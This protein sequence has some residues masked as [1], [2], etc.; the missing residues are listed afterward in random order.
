MFSQADLQELLSFDAGDHRVLSL[1]LNAD[2]G[3]ESRET[4]KLR[5]RNLLKEAGPQHSADAEAIERYL[6]HSHDWSKP[7]LAIFSCAA[8]D[9]FRVYETA[10]AFRNRIR[11]NKTPYVKPIA[12]LLDYYAHY[13]VVLVD[14]VGARFFEYHLGEL[15]ET[16]GTIGE[17]VRKLKDG[18]G[19]SAVG[20]RG[21]GEGARQENEAIQR[22]L[23]E[24]A[25]EAMNFFANRDIRRLFIGGTAETVAQ[26]REYLPKQLQTRIANTFSIDMDAPE[27]EVREQTIELLKEANAIREQKLVEAMIT[28]AAKNG[29]A[30]TGLQDTLQAAYESRIDTLIISDGYRTPGYH[31]ANSGYLSASLL[32]DTPEAAGEPEEVDDVVEA[33]VT[34]TLSSG[35]H[36]EV[37]SE[38]NTLESIGRIGAILRY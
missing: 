13:G 11:C 16:E 30:V 32:I 20:M 33:A 38:N 9:F 5:V 34:K 23:R 37:I 24:A 1:Y 4:I 6:D 17:D 28:A 3:E 26:Y 25:Q 12:H 15:Q 7:G 29:N 35:G 21:G 19:S 18:R 36:V 31:Y 14:R 10:V 27:N 8:K 22:N 2:V